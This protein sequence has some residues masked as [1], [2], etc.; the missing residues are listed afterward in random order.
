[1]AIERQ[2]VVRYLWMVVAASAQLGVSYMPV[3]PSA[4]ILNLPRRSS[5]SPSL[6]TQPRCRGVFLGVGSMR[7]L[8]KEE[9]LGDAG[10]GGQSAAGGLNTSL[11]VHDKVAG[12]IPKAKSSGTDPNMMTLPPFSM[13]PQPPPASG[14]VDFNEAIHSGGL[15]LLKLYHEAKRECFTLLASSRPVPTNQILSK[16]AHT[17]L[18]TAPPVSCSQMCAMCAGGH[19]AVL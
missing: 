9:A 10:E 3:R 15:A 2:A 7:L 13:F 5:S 11:A 18:L 17:Y 12:A 16:L 8:A 4:S 19:S 14:D 6:G 1:M